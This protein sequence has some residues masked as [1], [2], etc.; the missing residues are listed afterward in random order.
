MASLGA[1]HT[2]APWPCAS[3]LTASARS[4]AVA[5]I[6]AATVLAAASTAAETLVVS[7]RLPS[8]AVPATRANGV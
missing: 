1:E 7:L 5:V 4:A 6:V 3:E 2:G 8:A